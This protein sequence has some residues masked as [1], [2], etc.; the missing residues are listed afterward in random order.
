MKMS[1]ESC[2]VSL[3]ADGYERK[4]KRAGSFLLLILMIYTAVDFETAQRWERD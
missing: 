1:A 4:E 2:S 3:L